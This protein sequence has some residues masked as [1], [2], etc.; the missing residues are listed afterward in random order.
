MTQVASQRSPVCFIPQPDGAYYGL[1]TGHV[2]VHLRQ[3]S[4]V[5]RAVYKSQ[6]MTLKTVL[7]VIRDDRVQCPPS[8]VCGEG[9]MICQTLHFQEVLVGIPFQVVIEITH[10]QHVAA[11]VCHHQVVKGLSK[12]QE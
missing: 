4:V 5:V 6:L 12:E 7:L 9:D 3:Y 10:N 2:H 8:F 11:A 1:V